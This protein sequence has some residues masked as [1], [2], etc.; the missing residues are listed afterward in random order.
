MVAANIFP[1]IKGVGVASGIFECIAFAFHDVVALCLVATLIDAAIRINGY[2]AHIF[3][4]RKFFIGGL[5][6]NEDMIVRAFIW[7]MNIFAA[8][9]GA[10]MLNGKVCRAVKGNRLEEGTGRFAWSEFA[11]PV[12]PFAVKFPVVFVLEIDSSEA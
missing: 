3:V 7:A 12:V 5:D 6:G 11:F 1:M 8:L 4:A 10:D 9:V 2:G